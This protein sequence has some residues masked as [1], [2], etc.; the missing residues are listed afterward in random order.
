MQNSAL[1]CR[2]FEALGL[3]QK[4]ELGMLGSFLYLHITSSILPPDTSA[5]YQWQCD[6]CYKQQHS[7]LAGT[8]GG[9]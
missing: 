6:A 8:L 2:A 3:T 7:N 4:Q 9:V 5:C 1:R